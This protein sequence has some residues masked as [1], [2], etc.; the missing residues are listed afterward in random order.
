MVDEPERRAL[1]ERLHVLDALVIALDRRGELVQVVGSAVDMDLARCALIELFE[2][3]AV[4]A[5]VVLDL[6][7]RRFAELQRQ[8]IIDERQQVIA[9]LAAL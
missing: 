6:Q 5:Q 2:F 8:Q 4:Q 9:R 1:R 7:V 3:D